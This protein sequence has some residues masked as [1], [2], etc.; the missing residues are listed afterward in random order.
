M[1]Y[2][3]IGFILGIIFVVVIGKWSGFIKWKVEKK[4]QQK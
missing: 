4:V 3:Y 2:S 1:T